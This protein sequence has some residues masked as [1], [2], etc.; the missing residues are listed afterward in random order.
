MELERQDLTTIAGLSAVLAEDPLAINA[1]F[2]NL[3]NETWVWG[4]SEKTLLD[5]LLGAKRD[6]KREVAF[7]L[8]RGASVRI[9]DPLATACYNGQKGAI[10][11]LVEHGAPVNG[12]RGKDSCGFVPLLWCAEGAAAGRATVELLRAEG[13]VLGRRQ[14]CGDRFLHILARS[15][16]SASERRAAARAFLGKLREGSILVNAKNSEGYTALQLA[17]NA[18][19]P[20]LVALLVKHGAR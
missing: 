9:G 17:K 18:G 4:D 10:R 16:S 14:R 1:R 8:K 15:R 19:D 11:L 3:E 5:N 12:N 6:V 20:R 13:V 2:S 7:L